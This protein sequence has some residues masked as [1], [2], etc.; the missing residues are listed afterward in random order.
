MQSLTL[1]TTFC[2]LSPPHSLTHSH[3]VPLSFRFFASVATTVFGLPDAFPTM[4]AH[5][6]RQTRDSHIETQDER[7]HERRLGDSNEAESPAADAWEER[8]PPLV[9][10]KC[11]A[12]ASWSRQVLLCGRCR[13]PYCTEC[14]WT[15]CQ[16]KQDRRGRPG[17]DGNRPLCPSCRSSLLRLPDALLRYIL[18]FL[19]YRNQDRLLSVC[20]RFSSVIWVPYDYVKSIEDLLQWREPF[21]ILH[22]SPRS[23]VLRGAI[24]EGGEVLAVK[25]MPKSS[26]LSRRLWQRMQDYLDIRI[27]CNFFQSSAPNGASA[28][29]PFPAVCRVF[30]NRDLVCVGSVFVDPTRLVPLFDCLQFATSS[31]T[32][33]SCL[34][35]ET[36]AVW[37]ET[38]C[39]RLLRKLLDAVGWMHETLGAVHRNISLESIH[40]DMS[41]GHENYE[42][43][44]LGFWSARFVTPR[45][46]RRRF[47]VASSK[48]DSPQT[49]AME[50]G[51]E[52]PHA[53]S[54]FNG[55]G[56]PLPKHAT[57]FPF[58]DAASPSPCSS[59]PGHA[60]ATM[61][62]KPVRPILLPR[63][64][65]ASV[66]RSADM[67]SRV[68]KEREA[69]LASGNFTQRFVRP[70]HYT[71]RLFLA[72]R[73]HRSGRSG[74][75]G[76]P[77]SGSIS[78][79]DGD[80]GGAGIP[81]VEESDSDDAEL[82]VGTPRAA[83]GFAAPEL[84]PALAAKSTIPSTGASAKDM[85]AW[86]V[87]AIGGVW[88][89]LLS[90]HVREQKWRKDRSQ[91]TTVL[92]LPPLSTL[93]EVKATVS[94]GS[95]ELLLRLLHVNPQKRWTCRQALLFVDELLETAVG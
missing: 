58:S 93:E 59:V 76:L 53:D 79:G 46:S 47:P 82:L 8:I 40:M 43:R 83:A 67:Y 39:L 31:T 30:H 13:F 22:T 73:S 74:S 75:L 29:A 60:D 34:T 87:F 65:G 84:L 77:P 45:S 70:A 55:G 16:T 25:L 81:A 61:R 94:A 21:D 27:G 57:T 52:T 15:E 50:S 20:T 2:F 23:V 86:D 80:G 1:F 14:M 4:G 28:T 51:R 90:A 6:S 12:S 64:T 95:W 17:G 71:Q 18:L 9:C 32:P 33:D 92:G 78:M 63:S 89:H 72:Q 36:S 35:R 26:L 38:A 56:F 10:A 11:L 7:A 66:Q 91:G 41:K 42:V 62:K 5:L 88:Y 68:A 69:V 85:Q 3:S 19:P 44:L 24:R 54:A 48:D 49:A 37:C